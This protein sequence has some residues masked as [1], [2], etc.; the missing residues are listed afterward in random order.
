M[1]WC[2]DPLLLWEKDFGQK[3]V[4]GK[5]RE[6]RKASS[7]GSTVSELP[8]VPVHLPPQQS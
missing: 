7:Q 6:A 5:V 4:P 8:T 2:S 3:L 1:G